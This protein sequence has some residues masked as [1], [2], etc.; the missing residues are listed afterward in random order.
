M[1]LITDHQDAKK[2][3]AALYRHLTPG[4]TLVLEIETVASIPHPCGVRRRAM[5]TRS[6]GSKIVLSFITT[7]QPEIQLF[8]SRAHYESIVDGIVQETQDELFE[9][10]LYCFDEL[11][12]LLQ[13]VGFTNIKKFAAFDR[14]KIVYQA[15]PIIVYECVK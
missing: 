11:D 14:T 15:T 3:L 1:G 2:A 7:Y 13:E 10:Y 12:I 4:G 9:Q 6:D 8:T 5:H